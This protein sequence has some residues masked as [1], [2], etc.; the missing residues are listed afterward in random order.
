MERQQAEDLAY[1]R[2]LDKAKS[3]QTA[4]ADDTHAGHQLLISKKKVFLKG[5]ILKIKGFW[6]ENKGFSG[7]L[8]G[9]T[10]G[11]KGFFLL[12]ATQIRTVINNITK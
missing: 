1:G 4:M 2:L 5:S 3:H 6:P 12:H 11:Q 10:C 8:K 9:F 7:K